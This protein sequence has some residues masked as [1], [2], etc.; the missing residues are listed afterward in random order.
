LTN[1]E[2]IAAT[3][4]GRI[5]VG[6]QLQITWHEFLR[7]LDQLEQL[8][9]NEVEERFDLGMKQLL[10]KIVPNYQA[11][12]SAEQQEKVLQVQNSSHLAK[13]EIV[14]NV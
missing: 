9:E 10:Q 11:P 6:K 3:R 12:F 4:H 2:G 1:E 7:D 8:V 14:T 13:V 5:F